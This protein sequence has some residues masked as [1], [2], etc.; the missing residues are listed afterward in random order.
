MTTVD[1]LAVLEIR[2]PADDSVVGSV[3]T[4]TPDGVMTAIAAAKGW[5][6]VGPPHRPPNAGSR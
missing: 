3:K 1:R 5:P 6:R 2:D 4:A